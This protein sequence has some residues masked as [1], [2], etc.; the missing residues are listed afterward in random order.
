VPVAAPPPP[1]A[2]STAKPTAATPRSA[3]AGEGWFVQ[4]A[5][6]KSRENAD[7]QVSQLKAKGYTA[8]VQAD[9]G[10]LFRVRIGPFQERAEASKTAERLQR[11]DNIGAS[12]G[13]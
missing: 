2:A 7:R 4:V 3:P 1:P 10:S 6:F 13:R 12:V 5:A 9:P 8:I 11:E